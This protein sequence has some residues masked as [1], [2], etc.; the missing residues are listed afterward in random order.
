MHPLAHYRSHLF[1]ALE[2]ATCGMGPFP[3]NACPP[4]WTA[5]PGRLC[6]EFSLFSIAMLLLSGALVSGPYALITTAVSA[7]LVSQTLLPLLRSSTASTGETLHSLFIESLCLE[8][9]LASVPGH[10]PSALLL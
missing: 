10:P 7:D 8:S 6:S 1:C 9:F 2:M 4:R 3:I 5:G